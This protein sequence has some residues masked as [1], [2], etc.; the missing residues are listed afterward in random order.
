MLE[1]DRVGQRP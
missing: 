1:E